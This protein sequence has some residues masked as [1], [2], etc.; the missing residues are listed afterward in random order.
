MKKGLIAGL[1]TAMMLTGAGTEGLFPMVKAEAAM[2]YHPETLSYD[3]SGVPGTTPMTKLKEIYQDK[4]TYK[5]VT[6]AHKENIVLENGQ[7][8][9]TSYYPF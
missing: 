8:L 2:V 6:L 1:M 3:K 9:I 5:F 4:N 7:L